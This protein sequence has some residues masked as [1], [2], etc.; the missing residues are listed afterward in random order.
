MTQASYAI[1]R[2]LMR[3]DKIER[4]EGVNNLALGWQTVLAPGKGTTLRFH[5][6]D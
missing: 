2:I 5:R 6:A 1:I 3:F 4:P